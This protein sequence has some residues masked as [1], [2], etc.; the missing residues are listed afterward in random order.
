M[1]KIC[2]TGKLYYSSFTWFPLGIRVGGNVN[3]QLISCHNCEN[4][5]FIDRIVPEKNRVA[6]AADLGELS[7]Q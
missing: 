6:V 3:R 1:V 2:N 5:M 4:H 7:V